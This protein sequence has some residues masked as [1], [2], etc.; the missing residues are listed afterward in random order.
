MSPLSSW[1]LDAT[2]RTIMWR[3]D[4]LFAIAALRCDAISRQSA[5][6]A[7][8]SGHLLYSRLYRSPTR[9]GRLS[10]QGFSPFFNLQS[11][12]YVRSAFNGRDYMSPLPFWRLLPLCLSAQSSTIDG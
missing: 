11:E 10:D 5:R 2:S 1:I 4:A 12:L 7:H 3:M 9:Y 8:G 6:V